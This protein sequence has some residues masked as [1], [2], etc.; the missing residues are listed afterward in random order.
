M[1]KKKIELIA[2]SIPNVIIFS[3]LGVIFFSILIPRKLKELGGFVKHFHNDV[4]YDSL[5]W[6]LCDKY[7]GCEWG[8]PKNVS[9]STNV[10]LMQQSCKFCNLIQ[11]AEEK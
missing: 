6:E 8:E 10:K 1:R 7:G 3:I 4:W 5:K 9:M 11:W 2:R